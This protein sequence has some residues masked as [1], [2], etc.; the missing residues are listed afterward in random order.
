MLRDLWISKE[1]LQSRLLTDDGMTCLQGRWLVLHTG[2]PELFRPVW[3]DVSAPGFE[4]WHAWTLHPYVDDECAAWLVSEGIQGIITD[5]AMIDCPAYELPTHLSVIGNL[6]PAQQFLEDSRAGDKGR[7]RLPLYEPTHTR[8]FMACRAMIESARISSD[9]LET[10]VP[11]YRERG[12][13][14]R[15]VFTMGLGMHQMRDSALAKVLVR[16]SDV[17]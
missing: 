16:V 10:T 9:L 13:C 12:V 14:E 3:P 4:C 2:W 6:Q 17:D 1:I 15:L 11:E 7:P 5:A 8:L